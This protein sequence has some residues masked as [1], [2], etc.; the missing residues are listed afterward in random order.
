MSDAPDTRRS[1][2]PPRGGWLSRV[3]RLL[4]S[5]RTAVV[6]IAVLTGLSLIGV[7]YPQ[8]RIMSAADIASLEQRWGVLASVGR[9]LGFGSMFG[10]WYFLAT[11]GLTCLS[12]IACTLRRVVR[13]RTGA[14]RVP[15]TDLANDP[16]AMD[17][18]TV[19]ADP[20]HL[21][22]A[23]RVALGP[24]GRLARMSDSSVDGTVRVFA[25]TGR[26]GLWGS[27][28]F[29]AALLVVAAGGV[30]TVLTWF[31]GQIVV[32]EGQTVVD[33]RDAYM[34]VTREPDLGAAYSG[35]A[36]TLRR[37]T[38]SYEGDLL[39]RAQA[40]FEVTEAGG[41][42]FVRQ[43]EVNYPLEAGGKTYVLGN[44]GYAVQ[45]AIKATGAALAVPARR[46]LP[47]HGNLRT[48][49]TPDQ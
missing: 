13:R 28:V 31:A 37:I 6:L 43:V 38:P 5:N 29:H 39:T 25:E 19:D 4:V 26:A 45:L 32:S 46:I 34:S 15:S 18:G 14:P 12:L 27:V 47:A 17:A 41:G 2:G 30:L 44:S 8:D 40:E 9:A 42:S 20:G 16:R 10:S 35:A 3:V 11:A 22:S 48:S 33:A 24:V 36:I 1:D 23:L 49:H 21:H 7:L